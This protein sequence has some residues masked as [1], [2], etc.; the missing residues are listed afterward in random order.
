MN[1]HGFETPV[2]Y[3]TTN[4]AGSLSPHL[5]NKMIG[6]QEPDGQDW[7]CISI[8]GPRVSGPWP[9]WTHKE[10][11]LASVFHVAPCCPWYLNE[12]HSGDLLSVGL[13]L[14]LLSNSGDGF[15]LIHWHLLSKMPSLPVSAVELSKSADVSESLFVLPKQNNIKIT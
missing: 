4:L 5:S 8:L 10:F 11:D 14:W 6:N 13:A 1:K 15:M 2:S 3:L 12:H 9:G 7:S